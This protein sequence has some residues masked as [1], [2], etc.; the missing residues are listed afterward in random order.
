MPEGPAETHGS[1]ATPLRV[2]PA[3]PEDGPAAFAASRAQ[4]PRV[5]VKADLLPALSVLSL[6]ALLGVPVGWVWSRLAP[7]HASALTGSGDLTM[8]PMESYHRFDALAVF[9]LLTAAVGILT[10]AASWMVRG[11]RGPVVLVAAVLGSLLAAWL[12]TKLGTSFASDLYPMPPAP[13]VGDLVTMPPKVGPL[14]VILLQ[15]FTAALVYGLAASWN[16]FDDLGRR[17]S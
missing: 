1:R 15:P 16:G 8:V 13:K 17:L 10:G 4:T 14:A 6:V 7:A 12:A 5:V 11:R 2:P 3:G 9:L